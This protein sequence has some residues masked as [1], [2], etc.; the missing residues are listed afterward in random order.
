MPV[1]VRFQYLGFH[2]KLTMCVYVICNFRAVSGC[3]G[4]R[5]GHANGYGFANYSYLQIFGA[6]SLHLA[7]IGRRG[8]HLL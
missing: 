5:E 1:D 6:G 3:D 7:E 4:D 2:F 8:I